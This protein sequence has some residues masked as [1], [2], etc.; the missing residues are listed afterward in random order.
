MTR[1]DLTRND[2]LDHPEIRKVWTVLESEAPQLDLADLAAVAPVGVV[3]AR[4]RPRWR[5]PVK[6]AVVLALVGVLVLAG[7]ETSGVFAAR[8]ALAGTSPVSNHAVSLDIETVDLAEP[9]STDALF[10]VGLT[11]DGAVVA[12]MSSDDFSDRWMLTADGWVEVVPSQGLPQLGSRLATSDWGNVVDSIAVDG[13]TIAVGYID[14]SVPLAERHSPAIWYS[15]ASGT[16]ERASIEG[17]RSL[18]F[19]YAIGGFRTPDGFEEI[20]SWDGG[21]L[22]YTGLLQ[23]WDGFS[24]GGLDPRE[25]W[26]A[27]IARSD[28]GSDW[29]A[30]VLPGLGLLQIVRFGDGLLAAGALEPDA[31]EEVV[32]TLYHSTDGL[33]WSSVV[34]SPEFGKPL[35]ARTDDGVAVAVDENHAEDLST[36][37][38]RI[39]VLTAT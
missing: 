24:G 2:L 17:L 4:S 34:R 7:S 33:T 27:L 20:I 11:S 29:T 9:W 30:T 25:A 8:R 10:D 3:A 22:A 21:Y 37:A 16:P 15:T 14:D 6:A 35:L 26:T 36:S 13:S 28:S 39:Y 18:G 12:K 1:N 32:F 19:G 5:V 23:V 38:T 31:G